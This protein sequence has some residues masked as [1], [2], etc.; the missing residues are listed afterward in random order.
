MSSVLIAG[1]SR[2]IGRSIAAE[3]AHLA[4]QL[5]HAR[6]GAHDDVPFVPGSAP[7]SSR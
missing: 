4:R 1:A 2:G 7:D 6:R 5:L 3:F